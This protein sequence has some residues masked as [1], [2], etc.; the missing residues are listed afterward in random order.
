MV[1]SGLELP[2]DRPRPPV[3]SLRGAARGLCLPAAVTAS[4]RQVAGQEGV[5]LDVLLL[6]GLAALLARYSGAESLFIG[7]ASSTSLLPL[8]IQWT[9]DPS[10]QQ[11]V[12]VADGALSAAL[13][14][15][16]LPFEAPLQVIFAGPGAGPG[17]FGGRE[18]AVDLAFSVREVEGGGRETQLLLTLDYAVDL[19]DAT[20]AARLLEHYAALLAGAAASPDLPLSRLPL[21]GEAERHQMLA[22]WNDTA[23][24]FPRRTLHKLFEEQAAARPDALAVVWDGGALSYGELD[25]QAGRIARRLRRLGVGPES[26]VALYLER[27][28]EMVAAVL[29]VLK[30]GGAYLPIDLSYPRERLELLLEDAAPAA[31][32]GTTRSLASLP[33]K[34]PQ[35]AV[36]LLAVHPATARDLARRL[37]AGFVPEEPAKAL[38]ERLAGVYRANGGDTRALMMTMARTMARTMAEG[39]QAPAAEAEEERELSADVPPES[40]AYVLYTSGSTGTPNG[41]EVSHEAVVRLVRETG[42]F[43]FGPGD[44]FLQIA[45]LS[46]DASTLELWGPLA[47]GGCVALPPPGRFALG[48]LYEQVERH[49]VT[50]IF[51]TTG[52]FHVAVEEGLAGLAGL[53]HLLVG[54]DVMSRSHLER[55]LAAL[56]EVELINCY[57]PTENTVF[58]STWRVPRP[59]PEGAVTIG[60]LISTVRAYV[61]DPALAPVPMGSAG[62]LYLSGPGLARGY[63]HRRELTAERFL[64]NPFE[65]NQFQEARLYK[66]GD[67]VRWRPDGTLAFLG[68]HDFQVK[69]RG[70]RIEPG[71]IEAALLCHP[72]V[73]E[74]AVV[75]L[76]EG[77]RDHRV[78]AYYVTEA[79]AETTREDLRA[80]LRAR[81]PEHMVPAVLVPLP[82][83]PLTNVGKLDRRA[84]PA[85]EALEP[86]AGEPVTALGPRAGDPRE[87]GD[88]GDLVMELLAGLWEDV[89]DPEPRHGAAAGGALSFERSAFER[90]AFERSRRVGPHDD[91]FDLGGHSLTV[92]RLL[93]RIRQTFGVELGAQTVFAF[94]TLAAQ[95]R[96][97]AAAWRGAES[98]LPP[99]APLANTPR[100]GLP[101]LSYAQQRLWFLDRLAPESPLYNVPTTWLVA[102]ALAPAALAAG[103]C[104]IVRRHETLRTRF[105]ELDGEPRQEIGAPWQ[106]PL[107]Q[108]DLRALGR[109]RRL[110]ELARLRTEEADRPFH[111]ARG[112]LLRAG[113]VRLDEEEHALLLTVHHIVYDG[114]SEEVLTAELTALYAAA[115]EG[116]PSP[117][118]E[119]AVQY[120]DFAAWQRAW[121]PEVLGRQLVWWR[122]EL[123][124]APA[125]LPLPVDRPRPA[126]PSF[127][128]GSAMLR[129]SAAASAALRQAAR[130][131]GTTLFMLLL[132]GFAALLARVTGEEDLLVGTPVADRPRPELEGLIGFFVNTVVIR[133]RAA[134]DP[135]FRGLLA[136]V[137][138]TALGA[139]AHQDLPFE[140]LV[141]ELRPERE[142]SRNPL[143]QTL[144]AFQGADRATAGTAA[145]PGDTAGLR[146]M[147]LPWGERSMAK[148]DFVLSAME[149][150]VEPG[151]SSEAEINLV[152]EYAADLF[153][154]TAAARLLGH[155]ATLVAGA[156]ASPELPLSSLPLL[157]APERHQLVAEWNDTESGFPLRSVHRLF[158][159]QAAARPDAVAVSWEGGP[160]GAMG[161]MGSMS[162]GELDRRSNEIARHL[163]R[164]GVATDARVGLVAERSPE[165]VAAVLGILKAGGGYL[166]LDPTYPRDR[167]ALLLA[168]AAPA[169]VVGPR[170]LLAALPDVPDEPGGAPRL[171]LEDVVREA[172]TAPTVLTRHRHPDGSPGDLKDLGGR[173]LSTTQIL[174]ARAARLQDDIEVELR[175]TDVPPASLAYVLYTSG[176][177]GAP[178]GVEVSHRGVVRLVREAGYTSFG[179]GEVFLQTV[180]M[181]FDLA[182]LEIW[183]PLLH[184]GRLALLP[185]GPYTLADIYAAVARQGVTTLW[186]ASALFNLA[187][188]EGLAPLGGLRQLEAGGDVLSRP[189]VERALAALPGAVELLNGYGPTENTTFSTTH[190]LR[191]GLAAGEAS[192]PIGRPIAASSAYVLDRSLAPLPVAC[193]GELYV[194]GAGVA[195]GYLGR[196]ELTAERF[197]PDPFSADPRDPRAGDRLYRT[198]D[199]ARWRPDGTLDFLGRRDFQVKVRGFRVEP[200]E[201]ESAL[202]RH[203]GV[204]EAVVTAA[205]EAAGGHRLIAYY[206]PEGATPPTPPTPPTS[207]ELRIHLRESLPEHMV[208]SLFIPLAELPLNAN[209]KVDRRALPSPEAVSEARPAGEAGTAPRTPPRTPVEE[210]IAGIWE[211]LLGLDPLGHPG[212]PSHPIGVDDDFFLL[213]GHSLLAIRLLSRLR[214]VLGADLTVQQVFDAP[215]IAGLAEAVARALA[216]RDAGGGAAGPALPPLV[217]RAV[218]DTASADA[219]APLSYAQQRLWF[220]DRL[221]PGSP[222][223]NVPSAY[224]LT[225][226]LAPA[227]LAAA[228][229][230]VVRRHQVLRARFVE[231]DGEPRL[232]IAETLAPGFLPL[233]DLSILSPARRSAELARLRSAEAER[234]FDL[235][236]GPLLRTALVR[237][238]AEEHALFLDFHHAVYDGWSE[239][240]LLRELAALYDAARAG[241]P[242]PLAELVLQYADFA[243]WQRAWP[244]EVLGRQLAYWRGQLAGAPTA[245]ELPADRPRPAVAS[246]R[247]ASRQ[248]L[249]GAPELARLHQVARKEGATLYM[250]LL[251]AFAATL[252][253]HGGQEDVL[254]ATP[255]ANRAR[256]E[257]EGLIGFFVNTL[258][259]RVRLGGDPEFRRVLASVRQT[260]LAAFAHQDLPFEALVEELR[261]ERDLSRAPLVQAMLSLGGAAPERSLGGDVRLAHLPFAEKT[262]AKL[263]LSLAATE[264]TDLEGGD[265]GQSLLLGLE[266]ATDLFTAPAAERFLAHF[267]TLLR[268]VAL[269]P[270]SPDLPLSRLPLLAPA[271]RHQVAAEWN[272][273][274]SGFPEQT[275]HGL[276][277]EQAAARPDAVAVAWEGG[278][279]RTMTYRDLDRRSNEIAR[280]LRRLGVAINARVALVAERSPEMVAALLGILKAGG[281]YLPLDPSYPRERLALLL[282]DA[283]P[284]AVVG[285]RH[286]LAALPP[287]TLPR[288]ALEDT[289]TE[290]TEGNTEAD[291][292]PTVPRSAD[293]PPASLAYVLYTSGSTGTPKGVEVSHRAVVRL[294]RETAY[295][296]FGPGEVFLQLSPMSFDLATFEIW[297]PLLNGGRLALLPP[298]PFTVAGLY[299]AVERHRVTTIWLTS[300]L[301]HLAVEEGLA[302]LRGLR[303][304]VAGGDVLS[305]PHVLRALAALPDVDLI[306]GYGPT[307]NTTFS[308]TH[309][310]RG[311]L[312]AG[313]PSVPIGRPIAAS[314]AYVLDPSLTLLPAGC[315]GE[316]YVGGAGVAR[317]YLGRPELTAERFLPD[318]FSGD[319]HDENRLYRTGDLARWRPDGTLDFLGRA[320]F[321]VK[322]RGFRVEP[323]EVET[324]LLGHPGVREAVVTAVTAAGEAA[325]GH[326]LIAYYVPEGAEGPV[327]PTAPTPA[328]LRLF[329]RESLPEHMVP[330]LFVPLAELPLNANG[331]VDRRA[332][333][334]P[335]AQLAGELEDAQRTLPRNPV[336]EVIA[337]IWEDLLG[338]DPLDHPVGVDDDFFHL[339]GHSLLVIRLLSRLRQAFGADLPVQRVFATP[340]V[341]GLAAAIAALA[342]ETAAG[343]REALPPITRLESR[344]G[345]LPLSYPQRRL[346]FMDR[347][348]PESPTYNISSG[349]L[350][351]GPF[352]PAALAAALAEVVRRHEVLRTR[353]V[354]V[355]NGE[356]GQEVGLPP[357]TPPAPL[358]FADL[359][360]LPPAR[361][362]AE[363]AALAGRE[364]GRGFDL[365]RDPMLRATLLRLGQG[366]H[367]LS[368]ND[369]EHAFLFTVHHIASDGWSEGVLRR[370]LAALY[371]A[372]LAGKPS[373]LPPLALQYADFAAWQRAWPEEAL[374]AQLAHWKERLAGT[375]ALDLP[376][377]RPRPPVASFR[378]DSLWL[379][380]SPELADAIR[381]LARRGQATAFMTV[382]AVWHALLQRHSG[383]TDFAVGTPVANRTRPELEPLIGVFLNMLALRTDGGGDPSFAELLARV[384]HTALEAYDHADIPFERIVDEVNV[385]RD[386]S[387][388]PLVQTMLALNST[389]RVP[390]TLRGLAVEPL[391]LTGRVSRFDLSLALS[392]QGGELGGGLEYSTDL[393]DRTTMERLAGHFLRLLAAAADDPSRRVAEIELLAPAER[394]QVAVELND[395]AA[396]FSGLVG[397]AEPLLH[398][399]IERQAALT[400]GATAVVGE[401]ESLTYRELDARANRLARRLRR[402]GVRVDEPVAICADRSPALI[403]GLLAILKAG[404]AYLP[405]DPTYPPDRLA[406]MIEDG[407]GGLAKPVLLAQVDLLAASVAGAGARLVDLD[408]AA[409]PAGDA[410]NP[411]LAPLDGGA[412]ADNLAYV[413]YTSGST[414]RPKGVLS[415]HR[416]IVN[417]IAWMQRAYGLTPADCVM[418]KTPVSFD[419]SVWELFWPLVVGARLVLARPG[420]H[421][422]PAYMMRRIE[423]HGVTTLHFVPSMLQ[424]F[425]TQLA[426]TGLGRCRSLRRVMASGE[427][428][429]AELAAR[430]HELLGGTPETAELHNL[431]GP[432]EA[433]VD[434]TAHR[435]LPGPA[436]RTVPIGRPIANL[437]IWLLD[438]ELQPVPLGVPGELCIGG[439][440]GTGLARGY[441]RRP[442]LTAER[443]VPHPL[444]RPGERLYRTGDLA[445]FAVDGEIEFLGRTD[446]QVKLRGF[447]IE[448]G[449][450]ETALAG[451]PAV[452]EAVVVAREE[453][454]GEVRLAAYVVPAGPGPR[455]EVGELRDALRR[456]LPEHMVPADFAFVDA[457]P[458]TPSGKVDRGALRARLPAHELAPTAPAAEPDGDLETELEQLVAGIWQDLLGRGHIGRDDNLFDVGAHSILA[459]QF[460][461]HVYDALGLEIPLRLLFESPTVRR[462]GAAIQELL[463]EQ[464]DSLTDEEAELLAE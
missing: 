284:A 315:A 265:R 375:P 165:M 59:L 81:L 183:G 103:L 427:A 68:R 147:R 122:G 205:K 264:L 28:A 412:G 352:A 254:I 414:G 433:S 78:V 69:V 271:E 27:S 179:P 234:P 301:F 239:G 259:L 333:P 175:S 131:E 83:L 367:A 425:L 244:P 221:A 348:A 291:T 326:R 40:L 421:R 347:L 70:F 358:P 5:S 158:E 108:V 263:D 172:D 164:M 210:V 231:R 228:L 102:G 3:P 286:L 230:E 370:E 67:L 452:R 171:A 266:Y 203:P 434:V 41:V 224:G 200:G 354:A 343:R 80:F 248:R 206:V 306:N 159:E 357:P 317:G 339:G 1:P 219:A 364:A 413:I 349:Y 257:L 272:D 403:V 10:L 202:L 34:A 290:A 345:V 405:L 260:A 458:L 373:P 363:L 294:V 255:V 355:T 145:A 362:A 246:L 197:V 92:M 440:G 438:A 280:H 391:D 105:V 75:G 110:G 223:Y 314:R 139:F 160:M 435:T 451:H 86:A 243:V 24:A 401:S 120:A 194:G 130:R 25:R 85:P 300:G 116:R 138:D 285:P 72:E 129:L 446:D 383:Q 436:R 44:V 107:P 93:S 353:I 278:P 195:R 424:V 262:T 143:V 136:S 439:I 38:V 144:F 328:D 82:A 39:T 101:A 359:S 63:L 216:S 214:A 153:T 71:E 31:V 46:F 395:T 407:L 174:P 20:T 182:T 188:E 415:T 432:T 377:D 324:A 29:G 335:E 189:H 277:A 450:I 64:P 207:A 447:R 190:R 341:A 113:L 88:L 13:A 392:V 208:P 111:L 311:G 429:P 73:R 336:E 310:L 150:P 389:P 422:D 282:A 356:P 342:A 307:E 245:L 218:A 253:R 87:L 398:R 371:A 417:R 351:H 420:G 274:A 374:A 288:L 26:R 119:L 457:L 293:V 94:P 21:L 267:A 388:P 55:A 338:L 123:A 170:R 387:R 376:A 173:K 411:L 461:S 17:A 14:N 217:P 331:K 56:P 312:P 127:R 361:R 152:V 298:G 141:E 431:Y 99:L 186:L 166:P 37:G 419:V 423:E 366:D 50:A 215:T 390:L 442:G 322:V 140:M 23:S 402:M 118:G 384:R 382:L 22:E 235:A 242:S 325:G 448:P 426:Q 304:L 299:A 163:R 323:G 47:N 320:D 437:G 319:P 256:P 400:P 133:A 430:F 6:A 155:Y 222:A 237:L 198:G 337:G 91:F 463:I 199:L 43:P 344:H 385:E 238:G 156:A 178:K 104:E 309:R 305:R 279:M 65:P 154:A 445:R 19:F 96:V 247:G 191:G 226:P 142:R 406:F 365:R 449:E 169:A 61:L 295:A 368:Q 281:G 227:A 397:D 128:G 7:A 396:D 441:L 287:G 48:D 249:L 4:L 273:T 97:V 209:G 418:Q 167:L 162:Y 399:W 332:L 308:T 100:Q 378:G 250:L 121:P 161:A 456:V 18:L 84:L 212:H 204:R 261:P 330:S 135:S 30:A 233:V 98:T 410:D 292:A 408:S 52:L 416:G 372:A 157:S 49:G 134:G 35:L 57:G 443:F 184:G 148:L 220:L 126:A 137:H 289:F 462:L 340:T 303:Q 268:G 33:G 15:A 62:E 79:G 394:Q 53:R 393:F 2:A 453:R 181:S 258:V 444:G 115:L 409:G 296:A 58:T 36:D 236:A 11:L 42:Y 302:P 269:A 464:I 151:E 241:A 252:A 177:T 404:G 54:G 106:V 455:P 297:G 334:S 117:L 283:A 329:L 251:A 229:A 460:S 459:I 313:E 327:P 60:R 8:R 386:R 90:S 12:A 196:P 360:G 346:Y 318:P 428:L 275:L 149:M 32:V 45:L 201:V 132:A 270:A 381:R 124:G 380:L 114:W 16:D 350:L 74:A 109:E 112:P 125:A 454:S 225:G 51:L 192:V 316:L 379:D 76:A 77:G 211:D 66:T 369:H 213:G 193:V 9:G 185:P 89:L 187:V 276:F 146:L 180:P 232:E 168:D 240:V 95:A 176:S 321:Q